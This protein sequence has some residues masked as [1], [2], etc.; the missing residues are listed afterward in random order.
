M[1][2]EKVHV[3]TPLA[4][5]FESVGATG[6]AGDGP[7]TTG[8][9]DS[10]A[11]SDGSGRD[12]ETSTTSESARRH[13]FHRLFSTPLEKRIT[14]RENAQFLERFRYVLVTSQLLS[15]TV[16]VLLYDRKTGDDGRTLNARWIGS[17]GFVVVVAALLSWFL[18]SGGRQPATSARGRVLAGLVVVMSVSLFLYAHGWRKKLRTK[19]S[20]ALFYASQFVTACQSFDVCV[21]R[22]VAT[23]QESEILAQGW[24][25]GM[26][27]PSDSDSDEPGGLGLLPSPEFQ[28]APGGL[29]IAQLRRQVASALGLLVPV[30]ERTLDAL[31]QLCN[32]EDLNKYYDIYDIEPIPTERADGYTLADIR[33]R[34]R[35]FH[36]MRRRLLCCMLAVDAAGTPEDLARWDCVVSELKSLADLTRKLS[37]EINFTLRDDL[38][39]KWPDHVQDLAVMAADLR[40]V[41]QTLSKLADD[42]RRFKA[43]SDPLPLLSQYN[44]LTNELGGMLAKVAAS[45]AG[46]CSLLSIP[47]ASASTVK[48]VRRPA[49]PDQL[50][51]ASSL[52]RT[53]SLSTHTRRPS[54]LASPL[55]ATTSTPAR[56]QPAAAGAT[57]DTEQRRRPRPISFPYAQPSRI[58]SSGQPANQPGHRHTRTLTGSPRMFAQVPRPWSPISSEATTAST[59]SPRYQ[60]TASLWTSPASSPPPELSLAEGDVADGLGGERKI[61]M[62]Q[63]DRILN[64]MYET[65]TTEARADAE[66]T[67]GFATDATGLG[68]REVATP[69]AGDSLETGAPAAGARHALVQRLAAQQARRLGVE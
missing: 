55:K 47:T 34:F 65:M 25:G 28:P 29:R 17:G 61:P 59:T 58:P 16:S 62:D 42:S 30:Y 13:R 50:G 2:S 4:E 32:A 64:N 14:P 56:T 44:D 7:A 43:V 9:S 40:Q 12:S 15:E 23:V 36:Q 37:D 57:P 49:T 39:E 1:E 26:R 20:L 60:H 38:P 22:S 21:S 5:Y 10:G 19:R 27:P 63:L 35:E 3:G 53:S 33:R 67:T 51:R 45:K 11:E 8:G 31:A 48:P 68:L 69:T 54:L 6:G 52:R 18:R 66:P 41:E 46:F 24:L